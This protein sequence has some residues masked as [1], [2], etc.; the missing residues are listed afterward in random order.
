MTERELER[1]RRAEAVFDAVLE[2]PPGAERD[3]FLRQQCQG[4]PEMLEEVRQLIEDHE[5]VRAAAPPPPAALPQFGPWQATRLLGRGGMGTVYLAERSDGAFRMSVAVKVVPLALA[6]VDIEER[7]RR[8]RQFLASLDHPKVARLIDGGVTSAGLPYLVMEFVDGLAIDRYCDAKHLDLKARIGLIRQV[9]DALAYVHACQ[10]IHRDL[11]PSNILIDAAGNVK[12]LDFGTARLVDA[13]GDSAITRTGVFAFTPE[14]ASPEQA[15]GQRLTFAS[16]IYSAGVLLYRLMTGRPPYR[17]SDYSPAA[18]AR[19]ISETAPEPSGLDRPLDAVISTA[20]NK[21]PEKRYQ[22]ALEM[23]VDLARYLEGEPVHARRPR[24]LRNI[25]I[26][27]AIV[28]MFAGAAWTF[29]HRSQSSGP[30][31]IAVLPF[32]SLNP[33]SNYLS[34]GLTDEITDSLSRF[35]TLRVIARPS[36]AQFAGQQADFRKA[37]RMLNVTDVLEGTVA[38]AGGHIRIAAKLERVADGAVLWSETY[39]TTEEDLSAVQSEL[40]RAVARKLNL[41]PVPAAAHVPPPEAHDYVMKGIY[42]AQKLTPEALA[43]AEADFQRAIDLDPQYA[44]AYLQLGIQ[45]YNESVAKGSAF[46]SRTEA[47]RRS[48]EQLIH[49]SLALD[50]NLPTAHATLAMIAMQYDWD[51]DRAEAELRLGSAGPPSTMVEQ[52]YAMLLLYRGHT[53]EADDHIRRA[54][55]LDPFQISTIYNIAVMR[56]LEGRFDE[57]RAMAEKLAANS[58]RMFAA[59]TLISG[60]DIAAGRTGLALQEIREW[61]QDFAGGQMFEAMAQAKAGRKEEALRLIRPFEEKYPNPGVGLQW[62]ALV[63]AL[64]GDE[65]N[66]MKWLERSADRHEWQALNIA[67]NPVFAPMRR[68][69][70]FH[71][72]EKRMGLLP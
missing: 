59:R 14:S 29:F 13:S 24:K 25:A 47:E 34:N 42:E 16:D 17:F 70:R 12:L 68:S 56:F 8:E 67:V 35:K 60:C 51:W 28:A 72:L 52:A 49:K 64:M 63:Y 44:R 57:C 36:V 48:M 38:Q 62:F 1:F 19:R 61:K 43:E 58:P 41:A 23:D 2:V 46:T 18:V 54:Q 9:L 10:V 71:A 31:S 21:N 6:S 65:Q 39:N 66:T 3:A 32:T 37:G 45:K 22:S 15:Q 27:A 33:D 55:D 5:S 7:F 69:T 20:L 40:T 4:D 53:A 26:A 30:A 50:P 11:K